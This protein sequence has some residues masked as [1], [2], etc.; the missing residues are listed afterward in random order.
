M[1]TVPVALA[2]TVLLAAALWVVGAV[3]V[4]GAFAAADAPA[5]VRLTDGTVRAQVVWIG[6]HSLAAMLAGAVGTSAGSS[7]LLRAG[8]SSRR[9]WVV[10]VL[11][12]IGC[13]TAAA[14]VAVTADLLA[15]LLG[16]TVL[17]CAVIGA[18]V[19]ATT[20]V[21]RAEADDLTLRGR[22]VS[23]PPPTAARGW[24]SRRT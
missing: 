20:A 24:G 21:L 1:V 16:A 15:L 11:T 8:H 12:L 3:V 18:G 6:G 9:A 4:T 2:R 22:Y 23:P 14:A 19:G 5:S 10:P 13:A 7:A 17:V